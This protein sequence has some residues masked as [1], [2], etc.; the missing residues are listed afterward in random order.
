MLITINYPDFRDTR[1][2]NDELELGMSRKDM[3]P[4][5]I[6]ADSMSVNPAYSDEL[7][8]DRL[9]D[10]GPCPRLQ[11]P[12]RHWRRYMKCLEELE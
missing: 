7:L 4:G 1:C 9:P 2:E 11:Q 6:A 5:G 3:L 8:Y 12:S 10:F